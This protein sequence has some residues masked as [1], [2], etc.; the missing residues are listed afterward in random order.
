MKQLK[1]SLTLLTAL[2]CMS[3]TAFAQPS[4]DVEVEESS[5]PLQ[6]AG[7]YSEDGEKLSSKSVCLFNDGS[8]YYPMLLNI[9]GKYDLFENKI[10]FYPH[11]RDTFEVYARHNPLIETST[12]NFTGF[13]LDTLIDFDNSEFNYIPVEL[14]SCYWQ[15]KV[16]IYNHPNRVQQFS[17]AYAPHDGQATQTMMIYNYQ[18]ADKLNDF[19][20]V[21]HRP[22]IRDTPAIVLSDGKKGGDV[23]LQMGKNTLSMS[24]IKM[25]AKDLNNLQKIGHNVAEG[26]KNLPKMID[27]NDN[28][29]M[30]NLK[31]YFLDRR[32]NLMYS[33]SVQMPLDAKQRQA[34]TP[35]KKNDKDTPY[36]KVYHKIPIY[37]QSM[38]E[39]VIELRPENTANGCL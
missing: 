17:L 34:Y 6:V 22:D 37:R 39:A 25:T 12:F 32:S 9:T 28:I 15:P 14:A 23:W 35:P 16:E 7:C 1:Y 19:L 38:Q 11:K 18:F 8:F 24:R 31:D 10:Y 13:N 4:N 20:L 2:A 21:Y 30:K 26:S 33:N 27:E 29:T 36:L 5:P 3:I